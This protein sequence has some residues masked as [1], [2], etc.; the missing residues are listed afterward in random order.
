MGRREFKVT[1][2]WQLIS[3]RPAVFTVKQISG[4]N[5]RDHLLFNDSNDPAKADNSERISA[6]NENKGLQLGQGEMKNTYVKSS[7]KPNDPK[8][9]A[10][11]QFIVIVDDGI[12][13]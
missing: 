12:D 13:N 2:E 1:E 9:G 8:T 11:G 7:L 5:N 10:T 4:Q 3:N 6:S